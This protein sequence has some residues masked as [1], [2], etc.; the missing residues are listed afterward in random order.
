VAETASHAALIVAHGQPSAPDG[1]EATLRALADAVGALLGQRWLVRGS[2]LAAPG[3]VAR[4]VREL[5]PAGP[6]IVYPHFMADGWFSTEE[7][8]RRLTVTDARIPR[9]LPA[10][11]TD[12][13][14]RQLCLLRASEAAGSDGTHAV[15]LAAHGHPRDPRAAAAAAA[16]AAVLKQSGRFR[17]VATGFIDQAPYLA[18]A[19]R[20]A[21]PAICL[22]FFAIRA[23]H[24]ETDMPAALAVAGFEGPVL[25]PIGA[26]PG[27]PAII[28]E[29]L[30]RAA[31][32]NGP[33]D[34]GAASP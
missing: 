31:A 27:V 32:E 8:P 3:S 26:D 2:T 23:G 14:L 9:I 22:P 1:P 13:A 16:A 34:C 24:V 6:L 17:E 12:P 10:F 18:D 33:L 25:D 4:A 30:A 19:A 5:H 11:G 28:A 15:L 21:P 20:L 29:A 7:L